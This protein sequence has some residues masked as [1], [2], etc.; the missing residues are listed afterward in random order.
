[1]VKAK[2]K[3][4]AKKTPKGNPK[5]AFSE[6]R[7]WVSLPAIIKNKRIQGQSEFV[8]TQEALV[9]YRSYLI[10]YVHIA[11]HIN[12]NIQELYSR[13]RNEL[14]ELV[15]YEEDYYLR[16]CTLK[17]LRSINER[18]NKYFSHQKELRL[19]LEK[20]VPALDFYNKMALTKEKY[21]REKQADQE[22]S[23]KLSHAY[24]ALENALEYIEKYDQE[25][26]ISAFG[27]SVLSVEKARKYW[28]QKLDAIRAM[29]N[30]D[31]NPNKVIEAIDNLAKIIYDAP[32]YAKWVNDIEKRFKHLTYDHDLLVNSYGK[33]II[34]QSVQEETNTI[35]QSIIPR[36]WVEGEKEQ[37]AQHLE[38]VEDFL[39]V[40]E[41]E[42]QKEIA[43]E[44]R[45]NLQK[46]SKVVE[47]DQS[48]T[49]LV[50]FTKVFMAAMDARDPTMSTHSVI[51]TRLAV[52]TAR[53]MNWDEE[54]IQYLEIAAMLHDIGKI[55]VPEV[56]LTKKEKLTEAD[57]KKLQ[58]H[59]VYG[60]QILQPS[61]LFQKITPW[62]YHHQ[63]LWN[64]K[65]YPDG[66]K[67]DAIPI[68]SRIISL[69]EAFAAMLTGGPS[70]TALSIEAA[71][72]RIKY[73][74]G[75]FFDPHIVPSFIT[76]V[77]T[78]EMEYLTKFVEK[79]FD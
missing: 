32:V 1:M 55:W 71:L 69:C 65:G 67:E 50:E 62:I 19:A 3:K 78:Q 52:A 30:N 11:A 17:N 5:R 40:Y 45:H 31:V 14:V 27:A 2:I 57:R 51:V 35:I 49:R 33:V 9:N 36:L 20:A 56:I 7:E 46:Q 76:A 74:S 4:Q 29:E 60:A 59:P 12:E 21:H 23:L 54:D 22:T 41:P 26:S 16:F 34:L 75:T 37:L 42:V 68:Q 61:G 64:G 38:Q 43:F 48:I 73:E 18:W 66:L 6:V 47:Q 58:M 8:A 24:L 25:H 15:A 28:E 39:E 72:E 53:V 77:E 63:E 13:L 10:T 79:K 70:R 44:E